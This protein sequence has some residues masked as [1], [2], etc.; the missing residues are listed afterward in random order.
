MSLPYD[1]TL[2]FARHVALN[3][4]TQLKRFTIHRVYRQ[5]IVGGQPRQLFECDFDIVDTSVYN[6][7]PDAEVI[8][9][10]IETLREFPQV[11]RQGIQVRLSHAAIIEAIFD[12]CRVPKE[13]RMSAGVVLA[14]VRKLPWSQIR[15]HLVTQTSLTNA[16]ANALAP[17]ALIQGSISLFGPLRFIARS[18]S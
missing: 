17:F 7:V 8:K 6:L 14:R 15:Q 11:F 18:E 2:P 5:N 16:M 4:I 12:T 13:A 3:N 9:I 10:A 1:L